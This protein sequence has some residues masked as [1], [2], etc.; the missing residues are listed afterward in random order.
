M[1]EKKIKKRRSE[2]IVYETAWPWEEPLEYEN[3]PVLRV[4]YLYKTGWC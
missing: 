1:S 4:A 2:K 3:F